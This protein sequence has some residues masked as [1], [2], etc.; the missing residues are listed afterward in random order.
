[1]S[2]PYYVS[3]EQIW[4]DKKDFV[5]RGIEQAKEVVALEYKDGLL[6]VAENPRRTTFKI[7]E[8]YD[9]IA[10]ASTG[11][12]AEYEALRVAGIRESEVKGF[13]YYREDVTGKWLTNLYSQH[14]GAIAQAWDAKPLEIELL[15][16]EVDGNPAVGSQIYY[17]DFDGT[18]H[19]EEKFAVIGGRAETITDILKETYTEGLELSAAL[20]L[21][22]RTLERVEAEESEPYQISP[23]TIE[24]ACLDATAGRRK[25]RRFS[26]EDITEI[27]NHAS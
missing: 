21:A 25:F 2:T 4:E 11:R 17:V 23:Q 8:I 12:V 20:Q 1:M 10:L 7:S 5:R 13:T 27:F 9:K 6:M 14:M 3:P 22:S 18:Y 26:I 19:E 15:V 16:C 24:V